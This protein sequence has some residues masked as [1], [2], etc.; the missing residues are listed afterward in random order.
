LIV[1]SGLSELASSD[2][3]IKDTRCRAQEDIAFAFVGAVVPDEPKFHTA[4]FA[5]AGQMY[6][7]ELL[8]GL[9]RAGLRASAIIS[10]MPFPSRRHRK[11]SRVWVGG[12]RVDFAEGLS[13]TLLPFINITPLKQISVGM[14]TLFELLRWGWRNRRARFRIVHCYNLSV[15]PGLFILLS[16]RLIRA[17]AVVSLCDIDV[18]GETVPAGLYWKLDY[19][20]QRR[21][22]PRFDGHTV[23]SD[24][25]AR[26]FLPGRPYVRLE[27]A[28][29]KELFEGMTTSHRA[30][31]EAGTPFVITA[32]GRLDKTNGF[33]EILKAFA[34]L[35]GDRYRLRIAGA[36]PLEEQVREAAMKNP[37]IEFRGLLSFSDVL[38]LYTSS[39]V[40]INMR[41]TKSRNTK[42][43]FPSKM[44]DYLASGVPVITTCTGHAEAEYANFA[45]LLREETPEALS[46]MIQR[47]EALSTE[48]RQGIG[49]QAQQYMFAQKTWR[50]QAEKVAEFIRS[51]VLRTGLEATP[52]D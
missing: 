38:E 19:W 9:K 48:E 41:M 27:G 1:F 40:L 51:A 52:G 30:Q 46:G 37:R 34:L 21:L 10:V 39:D 22:I 11:G 42:Y 43:F 23:A 35:P 8:L 50:A 45:F 49:R 32:V 47:V 29:R 26:D 24:A 31:R 3:L 13:I 4:A 28:I 15:P 14:A 17:K 16:A 5:R 44:M 6:Q 12:G 36:G 20:L 18:P 25:I 2:I 7:E 33:P